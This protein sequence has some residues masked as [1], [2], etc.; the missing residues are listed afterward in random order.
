MRRQGGA[1]HAVEHRHVVPVG[2]SAK[3]VERQLAQALEAE[4]RRDLVVGKGKLVAGHRQRVLEP[5][6]DEQVVMPALAHDR[7]GALQLAEVVLGRGQNPAARVGQ[8]VGVRVAETIGRH[9]RFSLPDAG[10]PHRS[11][12]SLFA[13]AAG[14]PRPTSAGRTGRRWRLHL[15]LSQGSN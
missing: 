1:G 13:Q 12:P 10:M 4:R 9:A 2:R 15:A 5:G 7:P 8:S 3:M 14:L 6:E 11:C